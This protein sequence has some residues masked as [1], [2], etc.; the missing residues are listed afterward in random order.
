MNGVRA[1]VRHWALTLL[2]L[3]KTVDIAQNHELVKVVSIDLDACRV[4][5]WP[6]KE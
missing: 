1:T 3:V 2:T 5:Y 6:W 4:S